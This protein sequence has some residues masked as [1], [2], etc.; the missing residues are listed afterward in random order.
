MQDSEVD[1]F[2][3]Q[4]VRDAVPRSVP[5]WALPHPNRFTQFHAFVTWSDGCDEKGNFI[6]HCPLH[7]KD[8]EDEDVASAEFN[9]HK[10]IMRCFGDPSCHPGKRA[11]SLDTVARR[12]ADGQV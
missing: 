3:E 10:G 7:D 2:D 11:V 9:F 4:A 12:M 5:G 1:V 6:G 8:D